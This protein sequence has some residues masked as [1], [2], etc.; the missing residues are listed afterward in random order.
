M[1]HPPK[2]RMLEPSIPV[3]GT[4]FED[5]GISR[6]SGL[7]GRDGPPWAGLQ[8]QSASGFR[9]C[10]LPGLP[11]MKSSDTSSGHMV[12]LPH[13]FTTM[14]DHRYE[15]VSQDLFLSHFFYRL[16]FHHSNVKIRKLAVSQHTYMLSIAS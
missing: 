6:V 2:V 15:I 11:H 12:L 3:V 9:C 13:V 8:G 1:K 14:M 4:H 7:A 10:L 5:G 16:S